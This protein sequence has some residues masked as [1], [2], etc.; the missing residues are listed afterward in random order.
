[1]TQ[2]QEQKLRHDYE[3][4]RMDLM[5]IAQN[6]GISYTEARNY[7]HSA[8]DENFIINRPETEHDIDENGQPLKY[9]PKP[10]KAKKKAKKETKAMQEEK[11]EQPEI[12]PKPEAKEEQ[13]EVMAKEKPTRWQIIA[14]HLVQ[15]SLQLKMLEAE[16]QKF[17]QDTR[18]EFLNLTNEMS[19]AMKQAEDK[20]REE[21][22]KRILTLINQQ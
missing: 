2:E 18:E 9:K 22:R 4:T 21:E 16:Q 14:A 1:M 13:A 3:T 20:A 19:A 10:E 15:I 5:R 6:I 17:M 11:T 8:Y 12:Q 7:V